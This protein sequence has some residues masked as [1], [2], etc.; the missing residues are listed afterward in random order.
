MAYNYFPQNYQMPAYYPQVQQPQMPGTQMS[1]ANQPQQQTS[2]DIKWVQG[3]AGAKSYMVAPNTS[4]TLW[5]SEAHTIYI[6][7][8]NA[9]GL[10]SM[11]IID[12]T[13]RNDSAQDRAVLAESDFAKQSDVDYLKSE[14]EALR[15]KFGEIEGGKKK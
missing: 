15:A 8:A 4:V 14:I 5:D 11:T 2:T 7:S 9:S 12:Y 1:L 6:K 10:P 3:E 13:I